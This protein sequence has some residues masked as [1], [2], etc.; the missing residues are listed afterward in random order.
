MPQIY[1]P[2]KDYGYTPIT[3]FWED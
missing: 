3:T 2:L 1:N